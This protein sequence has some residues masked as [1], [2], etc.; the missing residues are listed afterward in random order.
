MNA[1]FM[2][3]GSAQ[4]D[5]FNT[6]YLFKRFERNIV[7][8]FEPFYRRLTDPATIVT[9][10]TEWVLEFSYLSFI[11]IIIPLTNPVTLSYK[12]HTK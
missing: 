6:L 11:I 3:N 10:K 7:Y 5:I 1:I 8:E 12:I 2:P 4:I 9:K